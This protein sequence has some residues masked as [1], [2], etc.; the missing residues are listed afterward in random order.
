MVLCDCGAHD[1]FKK[2]TPFLHACMYICACMCVHA[3]IKS[4][5]KVVYSEI[6]SSIEIKNIIS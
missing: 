6:A 3:Y 5:V 4:I 1:K 2:Y